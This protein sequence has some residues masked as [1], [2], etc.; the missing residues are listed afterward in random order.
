MPTPPN[1]FIP[2]WL[3][4]TPLEQV[5]IDAWVET[6]DAMLAV[7]AVRA[8]NRYDD[9]FAGN[10][11]D[12]GSVRYDESTYQSLIE[13]F[14][15][16]LLSINVNPDLFSARFA[17]LIEGAVSIPE[18]T[19]RV[20][21]VYERVIDASPEVAA[22]LNEYYG[23]GMG[24]NA[25]IA[26]FLDPDVGSLILDKQI[27]VS[28]VGAEAS[29]RGFNATKDFAN[30]LYEAGTD[31]ASEA[32]QFFS[33]AENMI[34]TLATLAARHDDPDD[35]FTLEEF[36]AGEIFNNPLQRRRTRLLLAQERATFGQSQEAAFTRAQT[37]GV[38][39]L[40]RA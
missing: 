34:P 12:D 17:D 19:Q 33:L 28:E 27:A 5:Y 30:R 22:R 6:G 10:K 16:V 24:T 14:E 23:V 8:D 32:A 3:R 35:D 7:E 11:R 15:D 40:A 36:A 31:T 13:G 26:S 4:G 37:G 25:I 9:Y 1:V 38:A 2:I 20:E 29:K 18:F 21:N 39:G